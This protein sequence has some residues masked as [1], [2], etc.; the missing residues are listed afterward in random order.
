MRD[1]EVTI[2]HPV[3]YGAD[4]RAKVE[5]VE[6]PQ[7]DRRLTRRIRRRL[8]REVNKRTRWQ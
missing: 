8:I 2:Y 4:Y 6:A 1:G 5:R 3:L 7:P